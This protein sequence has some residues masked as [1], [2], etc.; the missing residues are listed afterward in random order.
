MIPSW[1]K[2]KPNED[3]S[4]NNQTLGTNMIKRNKYPLFKTLRTIT[5]QL[6][7]E[8][9]IRKF[10]IIVPK[11]VNKVTAGLLTI[12]EKTDVYTP[13]ES[14]KRTI[15]RRFGSGQTPPLLFSAVLRLWEFLEG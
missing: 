10:Q 4:K 2:L 9:C 15:L 6:Y 3:N 12:K 5:V 8:K 14:G 11:F 1:G 13:K 7:Q